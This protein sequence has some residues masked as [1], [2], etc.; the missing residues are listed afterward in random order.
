MQISKQQMIDILV[1]LGESDKISKA[2]ADLPHTVD[3]AGHASLINEL[4]LNI[5]DLLAHR[6]YGE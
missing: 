6:P 4:G 3:S 5:H 1:S 2:A